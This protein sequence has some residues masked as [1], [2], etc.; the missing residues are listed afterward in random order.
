MSQH[1][2]K[3]VVS[4]GA[5]IRAAMEAIEGGAVGIALVVAADGK[6]LGTVTDGDIRRAIL[7]GASLETPVSCHMQRQ[8]TAVPPSASRA[9]VLDL[10]R[11][12]SLE[13]I[14]IVDDAGKL[15]G[16][17]LLREIIGAVST[18]NWAVIMAGGRGERLKPITDSLPKPMVRVAGRPILERIVLHLVGFGI[19]RV[20]LSVNY[21]GE[22]IERHFGDGSALGCRIEYLKEEKPLGTG[23]ALSLLPEKPVHPVLVLNG[24]LLTHFNVGSMLIFHADGGFRATVGV[25]EYVH[26]VP[27][28]VVGCEGDRV[29]HIREK[30]AHTW[31]VNAGIYLLEPEILERVPRD[32]YFPLPAL[33]EECLDRR[34]PVGAFLIRE[35]WIDIGC[36]QDLDRARGSV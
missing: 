21:M 7:R 27:Y 31:L 35:D 11:A 28:G 15:V 24:D 25:Y 8:F 32:V 22:M 23:G 5:S 30:P 34:E 14:P 9:E 18:P 19:R 26:R 1:L 20:F 3:I 17:H 2:E 13:Q 29:T 12:R 4:R 6:L 33:V 10:M 36:H 16:L